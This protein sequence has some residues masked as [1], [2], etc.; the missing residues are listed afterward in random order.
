VSTAALLIAPHPD[1]PRTALLEA[2][3]SVGDSDG[4][5]TLVGARVGARCG[6]RALPPDRVRD[7]ERSAELLE[8]AAETQ[9]FIARAVA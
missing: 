7:V 8:L 4:I 9:R 5:A 2:A 3:S 1:E 6:L